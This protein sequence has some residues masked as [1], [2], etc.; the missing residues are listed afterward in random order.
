MANY[1]FRI[2]HYGAGSWRYLHNNTN[3]NVKELYFSSVALYDEYRSSIV[4]N[5]IKDLPANTFV[6]IEEIDLYEDGYIAFA[7]D[8]VVWESEV[9]DYDFNVKSIKLFGDVKIPGKM[10]EREIELVKNESP[11]SELN[12]KEQEAENF[13]VMLNFNSKGKNNI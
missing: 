8:K 3:E 10:V 7:I 5:R 1:K 2:F 11:P 6:A 13:L 9:I 12:E 4:V